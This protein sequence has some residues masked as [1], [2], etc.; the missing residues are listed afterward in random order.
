MARY[1]LILSL[2]ALVAAGC[3]RGDGDGDPA[4]DV[5]DPTR[6]VPRGRFLVVEQWTDIAGAGCQELLAID[7]PRY[8]LTCPPDGG[9]CPWL[10]QAGAPDDARIEGLTGAFGAAEFRLDEAAGIYATGTSIAGFGSGVTSGLH[11]IRELPYDPGFLAAIHSV[12]ADG[13]IVATI[14]GSDVSLAPGQSWRAEEQAGGEWLAAEFG[15]APG[16]LPAGCAATVRRRFT[17]YGLLD[18]EQIRLSAP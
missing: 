7:P 16:S 15:F 8:E 2:L 14:Q 4:G 17:N 3:G 9:R 13:T 1:L 18:D 6:A 10:W 12:A 5:A 11:P